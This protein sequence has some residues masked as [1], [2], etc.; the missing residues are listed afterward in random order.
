MGGRAALPLI[1]A[2]LEMLVTGKS[3]NSLNDFQALCVATCKLSWLIVIQGDR[4]M[5]E[6]HMIRRITKASWFFN[7]FHGGLFKLQL[8][9]IQWFIAAFHLSGTPIF[10]AQRCSEFGWQEF[11]C[12]AR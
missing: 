6:C 10:Q 12:G 8:T 1:V 5:R 4:I 7:G 3:I 11:Q 9:H 2:S